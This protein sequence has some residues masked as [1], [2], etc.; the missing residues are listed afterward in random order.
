LL[1]VHHFF[2]RDLA[3]DAGGVPEEPV[4][5]AGFSERERAGVRHVTG[6]DPLHLRIVLE[7]EHLPG[8]VPALSESGV[9][10]WRRH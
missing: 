7:V 6:A 10:W 3:D 5:P 4:T 8:L 1:I 2:L 9:I